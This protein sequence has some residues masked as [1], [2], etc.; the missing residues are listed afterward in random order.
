MAP[1]N[2][3]VSTTKPKLAK[4][5]DKTQ[6]QEVLNVSE[7]S[8]SS[9]DIDSSYSYESSY[10]GGFNQKMKHKVPSIVP[11]EQSYEVTEGLIGG[12]FI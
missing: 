4:V 6:Q 11:E 2:S 7:M 3:K 12:S 8:S 1:L 9:D 5:K 10:E